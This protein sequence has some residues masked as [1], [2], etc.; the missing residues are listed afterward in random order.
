VAEAQGETDANRQP[1]CN[2]YL[3]AHTD[4]DGN[5]YFHAYTDAD[6]YLHL[7]TY[8]KVNTV[9]CGSLFS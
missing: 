7:V 8:D 2:S 1:Q 9:A 3:H 5:S 4:A 6:G